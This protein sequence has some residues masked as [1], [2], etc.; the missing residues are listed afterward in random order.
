MLNNVVTAALRN[1]GYYLDIMNNAFYMTSA[2][3]KKSDVYGTD[4]YT[5]V[6]RIMAEY[7]DV[8]MIVNKPKG[9][10]TITYEMME[11]F[12]K[13]MPDADVR[14]TEYKNVKLKSRAF[15]SSYKYV[16]E[17]FNKQYPNYGKFLVKDKDGNIEWDVT[18]AYHQAAESAKTNVEKEAVA[19]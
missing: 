5:L 17:W 12:I 14:M 4:E 19:A 9:K 16:V 11:K 1:T 15:R 3:K 6:N 7:P 10:N 2:F 8:D 13:I 18:A